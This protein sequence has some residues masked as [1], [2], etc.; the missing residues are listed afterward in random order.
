MLYGFTARSALAFLQKGHELKV[1][2]QI[3]SGIGYALAHG[4]GC[5]DGSD[6]ESVYMSE[7]K[8]C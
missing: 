2:I 8:Q 6:S 5:E 1:F 4:E 7:Q 3:L